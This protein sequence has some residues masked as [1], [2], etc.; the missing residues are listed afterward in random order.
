MQKTL[1]PQRESEDDGGSLTMLVFEEAK[2]S[3]NS[4]KGWRKQ[5]LDT[6]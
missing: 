2:N 5:L 3:N 6:A 4:L 1:T